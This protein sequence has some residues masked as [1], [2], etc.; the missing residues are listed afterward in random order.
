MIILL[1]DFAENYS[2]VCQVSVQRF[3][4]NNNQRTVYPFTFYEKDINGSLNCWSLCII[5]NERKHGAHTVHVFIAKIIEY[6]KRYL[7]YK[8][9]FC[10]FFFPIKMIYMFLQTTLQNKIILLV[11]KI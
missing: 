9:I 10:N 1:L 8:T 5:S 7:R 2:F 3:Y 4:W 6:I 11:K